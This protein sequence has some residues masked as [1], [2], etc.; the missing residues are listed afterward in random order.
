ME[1]SVISVS[2]HFYLLILLIVF[3]CTPLPLHFS[4]LLLSFFLFYLLFV[5]SDIII[6]FSPFLPLS[7]N[8]S[9]FFTL[10][11]TTT[12]NPPSHSPLFFSLLLYS[13]L[14]SFPFY[15]I[16]SVLIE[17]EA[18]WKMIA[19]AITDPWAAIL[20][21]VDDLESKLPGTFVCTYAY[22]LRHSTVLVYFIILYYAKLYYTTLYYAILYYTIY[23][24]I[25]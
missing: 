24:T 23:C 16:L 12:Y 5:N 9:F 6:H 17:G 18:D 4:H 22:Y 10:P 1:V 7:F 2:H 3:F 13:F 15:S 14:S 19:I 25:L 20:N 21:D 8:F 11:S